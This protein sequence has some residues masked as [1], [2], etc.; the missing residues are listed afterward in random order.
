[1]RG[2]GCVVSQ[3]LGALDVPIDFVGAPH[4][5][6]HGASVRHVRIHAFRHQVGRDGRVAELRR[7]VYT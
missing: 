5:R 6:C 2:I 3:E 4:E 7:E 1:M